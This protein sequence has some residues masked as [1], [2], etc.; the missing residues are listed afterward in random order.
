MISV[1]CQ[2]AANER[3]QVRGGV[4]PSQQA[5]QS[6]TLQQITPK[7]Q[8]PPAS[9]PSQTFDE[10]A[11]RQFVKAQERFDG[12]VWS[13]AIAA[14]QKAI[15]L[16]PHMP[17]ARILLAR[18]A[19]RQGNVDLAWTQL[20]KALADDPRKPVI[21]QLLGDL[22]WQDGRS[23]EAI[24]YLRLALAAGEG[25]SPPQ[26]LAHLNLGLALQKEGYLTA[27]ADELEA[28]AEAAKS[29]TKEMKGY[30]ELVEAFTLNRSKA[31]ATIGDLRTKLDQHEKAARAY[32]EAA[33]LSP[34]DAA[35]RSRWAQALARSG[36]VDSA[37]EIT[38]K[39]L[40]D[41]GSDSPDLSA[42]EDICELGKAGQRYDDELVLLAEASRSTAAR[43]KIAGEL[44]RRG[45]LELGQKVLASILASDP[46]DSAAAC[47]LASIASK[48]GDGKKAAAM[49]M[50]I[51][52]HQPASYSQVEAVLHDADR[53]QREAML[54]SA[55][56]DERR[57][58]GYLRGRLQALLGRTAE[59]TKE[60]ETAAKGEDGFGPAIAALAQT[61]AERYEWQ[62]VIDACHQAIE[63]GAAGAD[64]RLLLGVAHLNL[65]EV[66]AG[67]TALLESFQLNPKSAEPLFQ[68]AEY[69]ERHGDRKRCE[70]LYK[71]IVDDVDPRH[72]IARE[73]LVRLYLNTERIDQAQEYFSDFER[74]GISGPV[75][76]RNKA[77]L[78]LASSK[79]PPGPGR[80]DTYRDALLEIVRKYPTDTET[81][82]DLAKIYVA[83]SDL[84]SASVQADA[85]VAADPNDDRAMELKRDLLGRNLDFAGA[86]ALQKK[87]LIQR[88]RDLDYLQKLLD[89][90]ID[91]ADW[92]AVITLIEDLVNRDDV[93]GA[94]TVLKRQQIEYYILAERL[95]EAVE[96]AKDWLE[97][98]PSDSQRREA[99]LT[100][101]QAAKK[102]DEAISVAEKWL[103]EDPSD[104]DLRAQYIQQLRGADRFIEA[105]QKILS[106]LE[107][108]SD[109]LRLRFMLLNTLWDLKDYDSAIE[110]IQTGAE[111]AQHKAEFSGL[112]GITYRRARRFDE[113]VSFYRARVKESGSERNYEDL[114][115]TLIEAERYQEA[116]EAVN[117]ILGPLLARRRAGEAVDPGLLANF[118]QYLATIYDLTDRQKAEFDELEQAL[119]LV[120]NEAK[121]NNNLGYSYAD[122]GINLDR[123]EK[124]IRKAV[125]LEPRLST[126]LDSLGWVLYKRGRFDEAAKAIERAI[127]FG[128][129]RDPVIQD[130]LG[131]ALYRAGDVAGAEAAWQKSIEML[132][133]K[134]QRGLEWTPLDRRIK[135]QLAEKERRVSAGK[136]V[137]T[138]PIAPATSRPSK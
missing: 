31:L 118:H 122:A 47:G 106:W 8:L 57:A 76:E 126:Y 111:Q 135:G 107:T 85:A 77:L 23:E 116:E 119:E 102:K 138:A 30:P 59:A 68:L 39:A 104:T 35:I 49:L 29:P 69:A 99:Y 66:D 113:A 42:I 51:L 71:R 75:V 34:Q 96:R 83:T 20:T 26:V 27:A 110:M 95:D 98:S 37:L 73:R 82:I 125:G 109:D 86:I 103:A 74:L 121:Y 65:E 129:E 32:K 94:R 84:D 44:L 79:A 134:E 46:N 1:G 101:L 136:P 70:Q 88:P 87:L 120:P 41:S 54:E 56:P 60:F 93:K 43:R 13:E 16:D 105:Q 28:F 7:P 137:D 81:R 17:E 22:A 63:R 45:K 90:T 58:A 64:V 91:N 132:N 89:L 97:A 78:E 24:R 55:R 112:L 92:N 19:L 2:P 53:S 6:L 14:A 21:Y 117:Q 127:K 50:D 100:A 36:R 52:E 38:R 40:I 72:A 114:I 80:L 131:D 5:R 12:Q 48:H 108:D 11:M 10:A 9:Q 128:T 18:A 4:L 115:S 62:K 25:D 61:Y 133:E 3:V 15:E 67:Q 123:A 130:H 124:L 33:T